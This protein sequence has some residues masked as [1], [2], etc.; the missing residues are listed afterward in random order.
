MDNFIKK[1]EDSFLVSKIENDDIKPSKLREFSLYVDSSWYRLIAKEGCWNIEDPVGD[2]DVTI[3]SE[4][5]LNPILGIT[6]LRKDNRIDFVGG[7][8]GLDELKR[9]LIV[10]RCRQHLPFSLSVWINFL[11]LQM[12]M[13]LCF[14]KQLGSNQN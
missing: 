12:L 1:L 11:I 4:R 2:L 10:E 9:G 8:R 3:L 5:V 6:D 7:I 14:P 13:K